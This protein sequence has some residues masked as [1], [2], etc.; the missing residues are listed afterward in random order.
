MIGF[1]A[2]GAMGS[3]G[4]GGDPIAASIYAK[5][6]EWWTCDSLSSGNLVGQ[7]ASTSLNSLNGSSI[8]AGHVGNGVQLQRASSQGFYRDTDAPGGYSSMSPTSACAWFKPASLSVAQSLVN[9]AIRQSTAGADRRLNLR[10]TADAK[11]VA[12]AGD[13]ASSY[14]AET[15][16]TL[17]VGEFAFVHGYVVPGGEVRARINNGSW[18]SVSAP[19]ASV[20]SNLSPRV[21]MNRRTVSTLN[22]NFADG[23]LDE[24]V[25]FDDALTSD[26]WAY[27]YNSG[28]GVGYAALKSA[29]GF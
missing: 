24:V 28:A 26:E 18:A 10:V 20:A 23:V 19:A 5:I 3:G 2:A 22:E 9:I 12:H 13:G 14:F 1:Y 27:L 11:L 29:A 21:G 8:V 17:T 4:S 25:L 15:S 6:A 7:H 16:D